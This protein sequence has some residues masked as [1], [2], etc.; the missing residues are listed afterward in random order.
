MV[1]NRQFHKFR[2]RTGILALS[3]LVAACGG[4]PLEKGPTDQSEYLIQVGQSVATVGDFNQVLEIAQTAYPLKLAKDNK[5]LGDLKLRVL[6]QLKEELL[7]LERARELEIS[8]SETEVKQT[9]QN[10]QK[11]YP[12]D[13]LEKAFFEHAISPRLWAERLKIKLLMEKVLAREVKA[14]ISITPEDISKY[15]KEYKKYSRQI[16]AGA[17]ETDDIE[18]DIITYL[19]MQKEQEVY[20]SWIVQLQEK[21]PIKVNKTKWEEISHS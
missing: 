13:L 9:L 3:F 2:L 18:N 11:D 14:Q 16:S 12:R 15:A 8:V 17:T 21:Y 7:I 5:A 19:H 20:Q 1:K 10:I 4:P 6:L